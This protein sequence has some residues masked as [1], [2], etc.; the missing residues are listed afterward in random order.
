M[1]YPTTRGRLISCIIIMQ[2]GGVSDGLRGLSLIATLQTPCKSVSGASDD[3]LF[4]FFLL[5]STYVIRDASTTS[6]LH[7]I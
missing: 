4:H 6:T 3:L 5:F 7:Q 1:L 2:F